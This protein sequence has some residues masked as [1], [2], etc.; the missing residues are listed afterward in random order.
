MA[1]WR[2]TLKLPHG[3]EETFHASLRQPKKCDASLFYEVTWDCNSNNNNNN[4]ND[5]IQ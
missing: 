4:N 1:W 2:A 3:R 5:T